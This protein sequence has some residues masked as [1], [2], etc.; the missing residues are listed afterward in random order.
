V[1]VTPFGIAIALI[2]TYLLFRSSLLAMMA[3]V[4]FCSLLGGAEAFGLKFLGGASIQPQSFALV[5]LVLRAIM[6]FPSLNQHLRQSLI[7]NWAF[8]FFCVYS[9][10]TAFILP[11]LFAG[12]MTVSP[13]RTIT[14]ES[15]YDVF[16]V[17]FSSQNVTTAF[18][19]MS[20]LLASIIATIAAATPRSTR[21][22]IGSA[23]L[24]AWI[25]IGFGVLGILLAKIGR[26]ELLDVFRDASYAQL[27]QSYEGLVRIDG[28]FPETS[29]YTAYAF[30]WFVFMSD[31]WLRDVAV[32][33]TGLT[34]AALGAV[35]VFSTSGTAYFSLAAY[36]LLLLA[37][38]TIFPGTLKVR[39]SLIVVAMAAA[40]VTLGL[41][42]M[43]FI[44]KLAELL[45]DMVRH[46]TLDKMQSV[47]GEQ[48]A[49]WALQGVN[50]FKV[51]HG[52]GIGSGS[53]RSSS[54]LT[55]ILGSTGVIGVVSFAA[56]Y[57]LVL[58]PWRKSTFVP[59]AR[60]EMSIGAAA[61]WTA[62]LGLLPA[63]ISSPSPDPG[64]LFGLFG[65]LA[66]GW[67]ASQ[68]PSRA[69]VRSGSA[70]RQP[71]PKRFGEATA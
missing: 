22:I 16:P 37:R 70:R 15:L 8:V 11:K 51:S 71:E 50:A 7:Q 9:A 23:I 41:G 64:I 31:L 46:M 33:L 66:L 24:V 52:L 30:V 43:V 56:H 49:F 62:C 1:N 10:V 4:L 38:W 25:H 54:I 17:R 32:R 58:K 47:S 27:D 13:M 20:T 14:L 61:S 3:F 29:S 6:D 67:R 48:R 59:A 19:I 5:F 12:S 2:G 26:T 39:K 28:I 42:M 18:Y 35:L 55:A 40:M 65:G 34:A 57:L 63:F 36:A 45:S 60:P 69:L 53:F 44:P 68:A 21:V